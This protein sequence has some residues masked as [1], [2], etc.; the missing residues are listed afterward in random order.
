MASLGGALSADRLLVLGWI[1]APH[2]A[3]WVDAMAVRGWEV[4][5][6]GDFAPSLP[7]HPPV[8]AASV[9]EMPR[10]G[11]PGLRAPAIVP[12]LARLARRM[13]PRVVHAHWLPSFGW[14]AARAG[15]R[16]LVVSAWGSD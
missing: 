15:V 10:F 16:P 3:L 14:I 9:H 11:V 8:G 12:W 2:V 4:H 5:L 1:N 6:A 7:P 13:H